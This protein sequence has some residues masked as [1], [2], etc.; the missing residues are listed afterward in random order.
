MRPG[1]VAVFVV[2]TVGVWALALIGLANVATTIAAP[3][4]TTERPSTLLASAGADPGVG[5][6]VPGLP[7][8]PDAVAAAYTKSLLEDHL[9]TEVEYH[10]AEPA[11][12]VVAFYGSMFDD[13]GWAVTGQ[14]VLHGV[15]TYSVESR[16][17]PDRRASVEIESVDGSAEVRIELMEPATVRGTTTDR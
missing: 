15:T 4:A 3:S 8:F 10:V 1:L 13:E 17:S 9:I 11:N 2:L 5:I 6:V 14:S 16:E 7:G 12:K